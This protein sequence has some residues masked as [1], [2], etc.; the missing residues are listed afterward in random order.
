M[1]NSCEM[2]KRGDFC[3]VGTILEKIEGMGRGQGELEG[4]VGDNGNN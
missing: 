4:T 3:G 1:E 2:R